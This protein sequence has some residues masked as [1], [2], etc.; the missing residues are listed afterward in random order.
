MKGLRA[1]IA[2]YEAYLNETYQSAW[3][4]HLE[5]PFTVNIGVF[6]SGDWFC[7]VPEAAVLE[8]RMAV[9]PGLTVCESFEETL[10]KEDFC[11]LS[12]LSLSVRLEDSPNGYRG[13]K[14]EFR[15]K[16]SVSRH[17]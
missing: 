2:K 10:I 3:Y 13:K 6:Q 4:R 17:T 14:G 12:M 7:T 9:P 8:G 11:S 16:R 1:G 15:A 5:M